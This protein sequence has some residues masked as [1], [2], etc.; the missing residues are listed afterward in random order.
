MKGLTT[1]IDAS[2]QPS[3]QLQILKAI[4]T[5]VTNSGEQTKSKQD[6]LKYTIGVTNKIIINNIN[7]RNILFEAYGII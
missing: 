3:S 5:Y 4:M 1:L 2:T 7:D 6:I